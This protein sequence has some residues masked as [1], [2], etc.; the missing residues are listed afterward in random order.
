MAKD[1]VLEI[2]KKLMGDMKPLI[3]KALA[4]LGVDIKK[5]PKDYYRASRDVLRA[6]VIC[7]A[8]K[9]M[10]DGANKQLVSQTVYEHARSIADTSWTLF[11]STHPEVAKAIA[12]KTAKHD[13]ELTEQAKNFKKANPLKIVQG[14]LGAASPAGETE[15]PFTKEAAEKEEVK[16]L[17]DPG[18]QGESC[19]GCAECEPQEEAPS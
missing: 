15:I 8:Q 16:S 2:A 14:G 17:D 18:C 12:A 19:G 1:S 10:E 9:M 4:D 3:D 7:A 13:V 5:N 6:T 11:L